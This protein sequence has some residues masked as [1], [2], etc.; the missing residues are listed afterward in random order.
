LIKHVAILDPPELME[1]RLAKRPL[2]EDL[3]SW[4]QVAEYGDK[5]FGVVADQA[6]H[7]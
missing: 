7:T 1:Q 4:L 3:P 6:D 2:D 5:G